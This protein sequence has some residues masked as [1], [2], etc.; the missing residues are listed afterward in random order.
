MS[1]TSPDRARLFEDHR[2]LLHGVAYRML[3]SWSE[4]QDVVQDCHLRWIEAAAD[5]VRSPRAWLVTVCTRCSLNRIRA[6][7]IRRKSYSGEWL[8]EPWPDPVSPDPGPDASVEL[9]ESISTALLLA[10]ERLSPSERAS[11]ILHDL[12]SLSFEEIAG[13]LGRRPETCRQLASRGRRRLRDERPRYPS[14]PQ[15]HRALLHTFF[16]AAREGAVDRLVSLLAPEAVLHTDGG[17]QV[18]ALLEPVVG[19][20]R[21]AEFFARLFSRWERQGRLV[22]LCEVRF[23]GAP[24]LLLRVDGALETALSIASGPTGIEEIYAIRNPEK[25]RMFS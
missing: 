14:R 13:I 16:D 3:G 24:G 12:F 23:N 21:V 4:A 2:R 8:P 5:E 17:G 22:E 11:W 10:L 9:D 1:E 25:L 7:R 15:E 18:S 19:R 6:A 20:D